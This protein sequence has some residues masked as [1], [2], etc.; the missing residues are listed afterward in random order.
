VNV[1]REIGAASRYVH[2]ASHGHFRPDSPMF[3]GVRLG[4]EYL[5][6]YDLYQLH[7]PCELVTLSGCGTGL[8]VLAKGDELLG[9]ERGLLFAGAKC[10][11]LTMWDIHDASTAL[12]MPLFYQ[13]LQQHGDKVEALRHAQ[14]SIRSSFPHPYHWAAF[15]LAGNPFCRPASK[16]SQPVYQTGDELDFR[17]RG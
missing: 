1:L 6:V 7:L 9:L 14:Q 2:I 11:L 12:L 17:S 3:S 10:V 15:V 4:D 8:N 16:V 5:D 13:A